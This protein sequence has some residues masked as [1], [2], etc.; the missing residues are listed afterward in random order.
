MKDHGTRQGAMPK[1][2]LLFTPL[3]WRLSGTGLALA[4]LLRDHPMSGAELRKACEKQGLRLDV[5]Q[6]ATLLARLLR[7]GV[8]ELEEGRYVCR[9]RAV[10][11]LTCTLNS[12]QLL[13]LVGLT[14]FTADGR[15]FYSQVPP[16][17]VSS[18][19]TPG[20]AG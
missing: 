6:T 19:G 20:S 15:M 11:R 1:S 7:R 18:M 4:L 8:V 17:S 14:Q 10:T 5:R 3:P 9:H 2:V 12:Q 16:A 13:E